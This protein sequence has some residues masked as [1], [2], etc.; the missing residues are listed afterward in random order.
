MLWFEPTYAI[1]PYAVLD[2][3]ALL[4]F[5]VRWSSPEAQHRQ[6][7]LIL[8]WSYL[9]STSFYVFQLWVV[10]I[11]T[12]PFGMSPWAFQLISNILFG[13]ELLLIFSYSILRRYAK[14]NRMKYRSDVED[15][16]EKAGEM[17]R[18][19]RKSVKGPGAGS[20]P[21]GH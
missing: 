10:S 15:W 18:A 14:A 17:K 7:H 1:W 4:Y 19:V 16:F 9:V 20:G 6:F 5:Y 2:S 11:S 12:S 21:R 13:C 8:M 3:F